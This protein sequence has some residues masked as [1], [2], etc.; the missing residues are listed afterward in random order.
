MPLPLVAIVGAPNVGKSTLFNR[1]LGERRAIVS[2]L[3]GVTRDRIGAECDLFGRTFLLVDTGGVITG[4]TDDLTRAVRAEALKAVEAADL[5]LFVFDARAGLTAADLEVAVVLRGAGRPAIV[6]ANKIDSVALRGLEAEAHGLGL[7]EALALSAEQ[8][9][10]MDELAD[11]IVA[12]LPAHTAEPPERGVPLA[13]IG[14]PNVGKSSLFNRLVRRERAVV[15]PAP[16]TTRDP[17]ED[18]F[19]WAGTLYRVIDTAGIRR[20]ARAGEE[21]ERV[22]VLKARRALDQAALAIAMVDAV[23]P[24]T[25][26]DL[27]LLGLVAGGHKPAILAVNKIDRLA[28]QGADVR[29]RLAAVREGLRF[30]PWVPVVGLSALTGRGVRP[31]LA[32]LTRLHA[33]SSRRFPTPELNRALE[34]AVRE[35]QPPS[36]RGRA[37]R[38]YYMTQTKGLPPRFVIFGNGRRVEPTYRRYL[39]GRLRA[40]LGLKSTPV[41]ISFR[42]NR[43]AR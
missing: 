8:G 34:A 23:E 43:P 22:S 3:P 11:R 17:V 18:H 9:I 19:E 25:H 4:R 37:V 38:F 15:S 31:L 14:R 2:D 28:A 7:G 42:G 20:H 30:S 29:R 35:K 16:G 5:V 13:I 1:L 6:L 27:T 21:V 40:R 39:E 26:Q 33:E 41:V 10:G 12:R 36:D 32:S 24:I